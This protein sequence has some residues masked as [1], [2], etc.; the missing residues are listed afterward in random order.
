MKIGDGAN[1]VHALIAAR[2]Q[3]TTSPVK[4]QTSPSAASST[5]AETSSVSTYDFTNMTPR[6]MH[7]AATRLY[8]SGEIDLTQLFR[9]QQAGVP[10]GKTG[11]DGGFVPL[12][13]A[14]R[15]GYRD[16]PANFM[17]IARDALTHI[18]Q[19]GRASEPTS[20]YQ[21]WKD[22]LAVLQRRQGTVSGVNINA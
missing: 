15:D 10:L 6:Q 16:A 22:I 7:E 21:S 5:S 13:S 8:K 2:Q 3:A 17:Q 11:P 1:V 18:E 20:G 9:L 19:T 4:I 14:E 12:S